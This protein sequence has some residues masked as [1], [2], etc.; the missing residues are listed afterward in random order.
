MKPSACLAAIM[1]L[2][3]VAAGDDSTL[4]V[5]IGAHEV[6]SHCAATSSLLAL[7]HAGVSASYTRVHDALTEGE[8]LGVSLRRVH[9]VLTANG[10]TA[11]AVRTTPRELLRMR[12]RAVL[13]RDEGGAEDLGHYVYVYAS[14]DDLRYVDAPFLPQDVPEAVME[15]TVAAL[16]VSAGSI[17]TRAS[18]QG[19]VLVVACMVAS[20]LAG[21]FVGAQCVAVVRGGSVALALLVLHG[22]SGSDVLCGRAI[23]LGHETLGSTGLVRVRLC[24]DICNRGPTAR[25]LHT[26]KT[27]PCIEHDASSLLPGGGET[28]RYEA[29]AEFGGGESFRGRIQVFLDNGDELD[30]PFDVWGVTPARARVNLPRVTEMAP[31]DERDIDVSFWVCGTRVTEDA[32]VHHVHSPPGIRFCGVQWTRVEDAGLMLSRSGLC[33]FRVS[34]SSLDVARGHDVMASCA[35]V[36]R[37]ANYECPLFIEIPL[38]VCE[39]VRAVPQAHF[40]GRVPVTSPVTRTFSLRATSRRR[41][42]LVSCGGDVSAWSVSRG[43]HG[44]IELTVEAMPE[45]GLFSRRAGCTVALDGKRI[46]LSLLVAGTGY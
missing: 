41:L 10:V 35:L 26:E 3:H 23:V 42:E 5:P 43:E 11:V 31:G 24:W 1:T 15:E 6:D 14:G 2:A 8:A 39:L 7:R 25:V 30:L 37:G 36:V 34:A 27:C 22:C 4:A 9:D 46:A 13:L 21:V 16:V 12:A 18:I 19:I 40:V 20:L 29:H 17:D 38:R 45:R 28:T 32:S 44:S 33:T